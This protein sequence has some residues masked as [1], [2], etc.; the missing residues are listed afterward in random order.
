MST[1]IEFN[2]KDEDL[3]Q[4]LDNNPFLIN[5]SGAVNMCMI[6]CGQEIDNCNS[7]KIE[8][9]TNYG[10]ILVLNP[11]TNNDIKCNI[12]LPYDSVG[13]NNSNYKFNKIFFTVPSLHRINNTIY[14]METFIVFSSKQ[15]D[16]STL[17]LVLCTLLSGIDNVNSGDWKLLNYKLMALL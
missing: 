12:K 10:N 13:D 16:G 6:R 15:K 14:D 7:V 4:V 11:S 5:I 17:K 3:K 2:V 1:K 9:M 8:T